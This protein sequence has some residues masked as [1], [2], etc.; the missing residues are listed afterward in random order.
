MAGAARPGGTSPSPAAGTIS[1]EAL[2]YKGLGYVYGGTAAHPGDWDC[3]SFVSYV[4]GHDLRLRL[5]GGGT[6]GDPGYPPTAH[7]PVVVSYSTWSGASAVRSP[8]AGDLC[9]WVGLGTGGHIGIAIS[10]THMISAYDTAQGTIVTPIAGAGPSGVPLV[11]RR[12]KGAAGGVGVAA[13]GQAAPAGA[14]AGALLGLALAGASIATVLLAAV[15]AGALI[16][17]GGSAAIVAIGAGSRS[18]AET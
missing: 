2:K 18:K 6:Y 10:S 3:S 16:A 4:L 17:I 12:V 14:G 1:G 8:I 15:A 11:Y 9:C 13:S 5:P 7:G